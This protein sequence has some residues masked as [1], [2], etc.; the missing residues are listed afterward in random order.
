MTLLCLRFLIF[1]T[2]KEDTTAT[3]WKWRLCLDLYGCAQ[4]LAPVLLSLVSWPEQELEPSLTGTASFPLVP[5]YHSRRRG[6]PD[7]PCTPVCT[8]SRVN[9]KPKA[10]I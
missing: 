7:P 8:V 6:V 5:L 10:E 9:D 2:P 1:K 3:H 4:L